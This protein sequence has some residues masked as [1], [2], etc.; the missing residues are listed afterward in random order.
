MQPVMVVLLKPGEG[1]KEHVPLSVED[2]GSGVDGGGE[3]ER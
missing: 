3:A 2:A 1:W